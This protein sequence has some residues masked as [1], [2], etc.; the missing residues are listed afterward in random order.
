MRE[1]RELL[2]KHVF[3]ELRRICEERFVSF[4]E[5][6]LRWGITR[7]EQAE[8][9]VL[10]LCL[11]EINAC[12]PYFIGILG[13]RYGWIPATV[14]AEVLAKERWIQEHVQERTSVTELE[15][16]YGV[17]RNPGMSGHAFF[18]FRDPAYIATLSTEDRQEMVERDIP[19]DVRAFG[20]EGAARRTRERIAKLAAL[21]KTIRASG[22]PLVDPYRDP[23]ELARIVHRQFLDL[24]NE[25]YPG[26]KVP[27]ALEQEANAH[28]AYAR[29]KLLAFVER[30]IHLCAL[31]AFAASD[32]GKRGLVVIGESG[33]G[34]TALLAAWASR[35]REAYPDHFLL[36]HYF[37]ATAESA[38]IPHF[39]YRLLGEIRRL[40]GIRDEIPAKPDKMA[41][42]LPLWLGQASGRVP[43]IVLVLDALNQIA[44]DPSERNLSWF[45][46]P[47]PPHVRVVASCLPGPALD[48][49]REREWPLHSLPLAEADERRRMIDSFLNIY[50]K[51]LSPALRDQ[52]ADA[53]GCANPLFLRTVLDELRQFGDFD[54]LPEKVHE[55]LKADNPAA[56]FRHVIRRWSTDFHGGRDI[57]TRSLRF[58]WAAR[59]GLSE[60]EWLELL[61]DERGP[62]DRQSWRP[63]FLATVAH[64]TQHTGLWV[65]GHDFLRQA[66]EDEL[67]PSAEDGESAHLA[68]ANYFDDHPSQRGISSRKA[69]EW[70]FQLHAARAWDRLGDCLTRIPLFLTLYKPETQWELTRYWHPLRQ[71]GRNMGEDYASACSRWLKIPENSRDHVIPALVGQFLSDN[72]LYSSAE[73]LLR[74]AHKICQRSLGPAHRDTLVIANNL[75][76]LLQLK[77]DH[78]TAEP[79][80]RKAL[81]A[82]RRALGP[83]HPSTLVTANN[84]AFLL[85]RM[86]RYADAES[87]HRRTLETRERASGPDHPETLTSASNLALVLE[88]RGDYAGAEALHCRALDARAR[89]LGPEHPDTLMSVNGLA[90]ALERKGDFAGAEPLY[91]QA[92][93]INERVLGPEHPN[94]L[95]N[96]CCLAGLL[97][98]KGDLEGAET[99]FRRALEANVR[100][101]GA[102][103]PDTLA[104]MQS[105][106][107]VLERRGHPAEARP[108]RVRRLKVLANKPEATPQDL[109]MCALDS[110]ILGDY[111]MAQELLRRVLDAGFEIPGT[112]CHLARIAFLNDD[113]AAVQQNVATAWLHR[114]EAPPHVIPR[115]LWLRLAA[116]MVG[117]RHQQDDTGA[118]ID[119]TLGMLKT[120]LKARGAHMEWSMRPVI[121]HLKSKLRPEEIALLAALADAFAAQANLRHLEGFREWREARPRPLK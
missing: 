91:R 117:G 48:A 46:H 86:G 111:P 95:V 76:S 24:I 54:R 35:Y 1:E 66:I 52:I 4:T 20:P 67:L 62:M 56:L 70:P 119:S 5:V 11:E 7:E 121:D 73:P 25:L 47:L 84:L 78:R 114:A 106:A 55:Y 9:K 115:I 15:I 43:R 27:G 100:A 39:L 28:R 68:I 64:L 42:V 37:G 8:G 101:L 18:Y 57:V 88:K 41:E 53:P 90:Y 65:P 50:R 63:L 94:T 93:E 89:V 96:I 74:Q 112:A 51:K 108:L 45:P 30:P 49:L 38:S 61:A 29:R 98:R 60:S 113:I 3:P 26:E 103:H 107:D 99:L 13:E 118:P 79:L 10:P 33:C 59:Q 87:L 2:V 83:D 81:E 34:K 97:Q 102:E 36:E 32:N 110:Y 71:A 120:A 23:P 109:R 40:A 58:L 6:D 77:G 85:E 80:L 105:L 69:A 21:K 19:E 75:A 116:M 22:V 17:L 104:S 82:S 44:G 31:D 16:L 14:P 12:R 72:G 92:L